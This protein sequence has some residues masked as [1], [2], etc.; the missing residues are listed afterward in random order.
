MNLKGWMGATHSSHI[1]HAQACVSQRLIGLRGLC[2]CSSGV[3]RHDLTCNETNLRLWSLLVE[4][5]RILQHDLLLQH[6]PPE[7]EG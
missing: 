6:M 3:Y 2:G 5:M 1:T 4:K 7:A